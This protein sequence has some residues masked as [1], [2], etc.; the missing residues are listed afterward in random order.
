[1]SAFTPPSAY[2]VFVHFIARVFW[3]CFAPRALGVTS[4][5]WGDGDARR[6]EAT[7]VR[8]GAERALDRALDRVSLTSRRHVKERLGDHLRQCEAI[9]REFGATKEV[10][11]A[12]RAH[13][14]YGS[15]WF[16]FPFA[17]VR[18]REAIEAIVGSEAEKFMFLYAT[19]SATTW[20]RSGLREWGDGIR[21]RNARASARES[22]GGRATGARTVEGKRTEAVNFYTGQR[23]E[24]RAYDAAMLTVMHAGDIASV[25]RPTRAGRSTATA[26]ATALIRRAA[27]LLDVDGTKASVALARRFRT[28]AV[29]DIRTLLVVDYADVG[30]ERMDEIDERLLG[31][32]EKTRF[33][34]VFFARATGVF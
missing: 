27:D 9:V 16:P 15:E 26:F 23:R 33:D 18:Q 22:D 29:R 6:R 7:R 34:V 17:S 10:V 11:L 1:M 32:L 25:V 14:A 31:D 20:F 30:D 21:E 4:M 13:S 28:K 3:L 19:T 12:A 24:L 8:V 5:R 2:E